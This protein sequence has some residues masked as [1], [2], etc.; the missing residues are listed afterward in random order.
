MKNS[1]IA[2]FKSSQ[3]LCNRFKNLFRQKCGQGSRATFY[4]KM[5]S[6]SI[7][8]FEKIAS[9]VLYLGTCHEICEKILH[10]MRMS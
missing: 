1:K 3:K 10:H 4:V 2:I 7:L 6:I 5:V 9:H 8:A